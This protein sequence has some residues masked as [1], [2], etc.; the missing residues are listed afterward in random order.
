VSVRIE[1]P[2]VTIRN[3][4]R[5][6]SFGLAII[7]AV[8]ALGARMFDLQVMQG[9]QGTQVSQEQSS[10]TTSVPSSRGLIYDSTNKL[11][12]TNIPNFIIQIVPHDLPMAD[13][14][15]VVQR[16][17][18]LLKVDPVTIDQDLDSAT[19]SFYDPVV[20]A[21]NVDTDV[22]RIVDENRD[23]LPGVQVLSRP[24]ANTPAAR[25]SA[26]FSA[27]PRRSQASPAL[28]TSKPATRWVTS[29]ARQGSNSSTRVC[30]GAPTGSKPSPST[31]TASPSQG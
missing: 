15:V 3:A 5:F 31:P 4:Y 2:S 17:A 24:C 10:E 28:P 8:A 6:G 27:I 29:T 20:V 22:A 13:K 14:P 12:V 9:Q 21:T 16:L 1:Q 30:C 7:V 23:S 26:R 18:S 25:S 19:G 11:L